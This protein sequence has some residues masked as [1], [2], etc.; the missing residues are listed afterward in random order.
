MRRNPSSRLAD[1][2]CPSALKPASSVPMPFGIP[3]TQAPGDDRDGLA[4]W[5]VICTLL[6]VALCLGSRPTAP[7]TIRHSK[8]SAGPYIRHN[9][10]TTNCGKLQTTQ[11][12]PAQTLA[13]QYRSSVMHRYSAKPDGLPSAKQDPRNKHE[14]DHHNVTH[15]QAPP[16]RPYR[17]FPI[18]LAFKSQR[19]GTILSRR[20]VPALPSNRELAQCR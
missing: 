1:R 8:H 9:W 7:R 2:R 17:A 6:S 20:R 5:I 12:L 15:A 4:I 18:S 16:A 14:H 19:T 10:A 11:C 3:F 13:H